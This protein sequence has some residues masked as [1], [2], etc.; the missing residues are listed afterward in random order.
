[1]TPRQFIKY[2]QKLDQEGYAIC[3]GISQNYVFSAFDILYPLFILTGISWFM[4]ILLKWN[5]F[6]SINKK[7]DEK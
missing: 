4:W 3:D 7:Q 2:T 1:M 6:R 5:S